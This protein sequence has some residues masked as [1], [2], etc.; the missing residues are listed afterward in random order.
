MKL[1]MWFCL[2]LP[3]WAWDINRVA[4]LCLGGNDGACEILYAQPIPPKIATLFTHACLSGDVWGCYLAGKALPDKDEALQW[5]LLGCDKDSAVCCY[6]AAL[7]G[8]SKQ[9]LHKAC[10]MGDERACAH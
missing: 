5:F 6:E 8:G 3:L 2:C 10:A 4:G 7:V 9:L 1:C